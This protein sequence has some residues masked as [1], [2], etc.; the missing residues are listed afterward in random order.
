MRVA[1]LDHG[2]QLV[3]AVA[4]SEGWAPT[5][6]ITR[7]SELLA[8]GADP[9][10]AL[11]A[12]V[13]GDERLP[14]PTAD[15]GPLLDRPGRIFCIG[16]NYVAHRDEFNN[17]PTE[18]PEVFLRQPGSV[19][20][21]YA[22][23]PAPSNSDRFDFEG[24]LGVIIGRGGRHIPAASAEEHVLGLCVAND[25]TARDW[26]HRG[27]QWTSGK[28]FD[29]TLP[30]GPAL[31][32]PEETDWHDAALSTMLNG[33]EMQSARTSQF[34]WPVA[35]QIEFISSWTALVPGDLILTGTPGGVGI[36]RTPPR[37][38]TPGDVVEVTVEGIGTIRNVI[39]DDP[40]RPVSDHWSQIAGESTVGRG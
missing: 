7:L 15:I 31:V 21:P 30:V 28:N 33:E 26:Q 1:H 16:R 11:A 12:L 23:V 27:G 17:R 4:T 5:V 9:A 10:Q 25:F 40:D 14:E 20:G 29:G 2:G 24:E 39:V 38:L 13:T 36:A 37:V 34:I 35:E 8:L 32:T 6:G 19:T 3:L 22:D 18:W